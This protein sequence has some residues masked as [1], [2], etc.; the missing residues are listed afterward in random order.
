MIHINFSG[1]PIS[2]WEIAPLVGVNLPPEA[3][4]ARALIRH[5]I[6]QLPEPARRALEEGAA[7][8]IVLPGLSWV[9]ALLLAEWH[10]RFGSFPRIRWAVRGSQGFTWPEEAGADLQE[11]REEARGRR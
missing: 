6:G 5:V 4:K 1:H 8:E 7:A 3:E 9:A 10:G 2:G 11:V